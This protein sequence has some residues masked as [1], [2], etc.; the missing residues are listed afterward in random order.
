M[1]AILDQ[2]E[3]VR[4]LISWAAIVLPVLALCAV[5]IER[6]TVA[7]AR[8]RRR[9]LELFYKVLLRQ[10]LE[11]DLGARRTLIASP[12]RHRLIIAALLITPLIE[13]R[14]PDRIARTRGIVDGLALIP[15]A[16]RYLHSRLWWR[17]ALALRALGL[18]QIRGRT[19]AIVAALDDPNIDVRAAALDSLTDLKDPASLQAIVVRLHDA[20]LPRG[21]RAAALAAFGSESERFLLEL[22]NVDPANRLDYARALAI[23]G[24]AHARP[25]LCTWTRDTRVEVRAAAFEALAHIGLDDRAAALAISALDSHDVAL[26]AMAAQ[27]LHGW[28]G[29]TA[30]SHLARHL[31]DTWAV[32]VQAA[33]SLQS[34]GEAGRIEFEALSGRSDLAGALA[35]Q[36][37]W[38]QSASC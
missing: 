21:R 10:A 4:T 30:A 34:M 2:V 32:A 18:T 25:A 5:V 23:C 17:R 29:P 33:R 35:R 9:R 28:T 15:I 8:A 27:A 12:A 16:D 36:M 7:W 6:T 1:T 38:E 11:G 14:N 24:T 13:D 3:R 22:A 37:L 19:A 31:D 26:R 20:R